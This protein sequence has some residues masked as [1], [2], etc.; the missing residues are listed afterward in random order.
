MIKILIYFQ[1]D[2]TTN[3]RTESTFIFGPGRA[4][5]RVG[6]HITNNR[7]N[8]PKSKITLIRKH[9]RGNSINRQYY[10]Y[11]AL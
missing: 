5:N 10:V 6:D 1:Y 11:K 9:T 7:A 3:F 4:I 2:Q 8:K